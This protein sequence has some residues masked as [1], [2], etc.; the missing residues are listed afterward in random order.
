MQKTNG[1][2]FFLHVPYQNLDI[3]FPILG[4]YQ[5]IVNFFYIISQYHSQSPI[6]L[7][8]S[9]INTTQK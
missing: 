5:V 9:L 4:A 8:I 6:I 2:F 7:D 3:V 1:D